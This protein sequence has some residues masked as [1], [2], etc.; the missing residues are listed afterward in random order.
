MGSTYLNVNRFLGL[1]VARLP[2]RRLIGNCTLLASGLCPG[3]L[4]A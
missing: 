3:S 2:D 4:S 1:Q